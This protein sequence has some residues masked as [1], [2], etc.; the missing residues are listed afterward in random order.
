MF[1]GTSTAIITPFTKENEVDEEALRRLVDFQEENGVDAIVPCGSTGESAMMSHEEHVRV[2]EIT[3]DRARK[4]KVLAG[5]GSNSTSEAVMLSK[6]AEDLGADGILSISPYYVKPTQEGI[7]LHYKAIA[8]SVDIPIVV[9]NIPG[10]T[11][12][13]ITADTMLRMAE[14]PGIDAVKEA[15][16]DVR[17][18]EQIIKGRP[19][20]FE[21]ISGDDA[22]TLQLMRLGADGVISVASNCLPKR[23]SDMVRAA[24]E[25]RFDDA[26][27]VRSE[28]SPLFE[29]IF[30][31]TNPI[32][33]KYIMGRMGYGN[34][35]PRL[36]LTPLSDEGK[37]RLDPVLADMGL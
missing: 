33:M 1:G 30:T 2:I 5:A 25:G 7:Y 28:L 3:V 12:S 19:K 6:R 4:A 8:E 24:S 10:R 17:Q 26:E 9:Y 35:R 31:E 32:P 36:P 23:M 18:I 34:G 16:G 29:S 14:I 13:N 21:V 20:G 11:G 22:L 27:R 15:S 37:R